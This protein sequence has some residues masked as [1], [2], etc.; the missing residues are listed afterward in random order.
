MA[1]FPKCSFQLLVSDGRIVPGTRVAAELVLEAAEAIP[2]AEHVHVDFRSE[3]WAGYGAGKNRQV[4]R[5]NMFQ[6]PIRVD[7]PNEPLGA[8]QHRFP[9]AIDVPPWLPPAYEGNDCGIKHVVEMRLDVDWAVDPKA[10]LHPAVSQVP[11]SA[12]RRSLTLR[13]PVGFH[14]EIVLEVT[15]ASAVLVEGEPLMGQIA[16]RSGHRARF[17]AVVLTLANSDV[18]T[19]ARRDRRRNSGTTTTI[20]ADVMRAGEPVPFQIMPSPTLTP[21]FKSSFI[22]VDVALGVRVDVPWA[23]DPYFDL[24]VDLLPRGSTVDGTAS[25][26]IVGGER[27]R[28]LAAAMARSTGL[29][30]G[31]APTLV[32]GNVGPVAVSIV[33]APREGRLGIDVDLTFPDV[34]LGTVFRPLGM[35]DGFRSSPLLRGPLADRYLL[36]CT[37]VDARPAVDDDAL[38]SFFATVFADVEGA[39]DVR[40]SDHHL[41]LHISLTN[42]DEPRM[43]DAARGA[44]AKAKAIAEA[45]ASLPFPAPLAAARPAWQATAAEQNAFLAPAGPSLYFSLRARVLGGEERAI[46]VVFHTVWKKAGPTMRVDLDLGNAPLPEAS[47]DEL[48]KETPSEQLL[49]VRASFPKIH[50]H[51]HGTRATLEHEAWTPDPRTLLPAVEGFFGWVLD[52][53][54]ERRVDAPYR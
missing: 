20:P 22:D 23:Q 31:H 43:V 3:A 7:L 41:G 53:R 21:S 15:L 51:A 45:I 52:V 32:S 38:T 33:D 48:A 40:F 46:G 28:L 14:E 47:H 12:T 10:T 42:D 6:A 34:E 50:A 30:E 44:H 13:S 49:S 24:I 39:D 35:L 25:A 37:P 11:R 8:G 4:V 16:L 5:R 18:M 19:M 26:S 1:L 54:G 2:R 36:R 27:L 29:S 17:D 9:F